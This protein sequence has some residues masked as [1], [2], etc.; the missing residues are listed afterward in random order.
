[1][2]RP[3][4]KF[5]AASKLRVV[6]S[7]VLVAIL[8]LVARR[9]CQLKF[10]VTDP[11]LWWH[12][13][14]GDWILANHALPHT[15]IFSRIAEQRPWTAY[16]WGYEVLLSFAYRCFGIF[17]VGVFGVL[18]TL[19]V[20]CA[21]FLMLHRLSG[22][23][24]VAAG[25]SLVTYFA[26]L[27][28]MMPRPHF[29]S[30]ALFCSLITLIFEARRHSSLTPLFALPLLFLLWA[31]LH[32][33]FIY[34]LAVFGL[35]VLVNAAQILLSRFNHTSPSLQPPGLRSGP[36]LLI[37]VLA[38]LATFV[39]PNT[40][41]LY[42][43]ILDYSHAKFGYAYIREL[44]ALDFRFADHF[45]Q[46]LLTGAAFFVLGWQ[47]KTNA[48]KLLLLLACALVAFRTTRDGWFICIPAA[49]CLADFFR[50]LN[51]PEQAPQANWRLVDYL[52]S[53]AVTLLLLILLFPLSGFTPL[54]LDSAVA[55]VFPIKAANFL[56]R[57]PPAGP[58][59]NSF[60]WGGFIIWYLPDYPVAI[61]GRN[62]LYGDDLD[63]RFMRV[64]NGFAPYA[65]DAIFR[66][67]RLIL[68]NNQ[69]YLTTLLARDPRYRL[70]YRD[71]LAS[72]F[73]P[74]A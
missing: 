38:I 73:V 19:M 2:Q 28:T 54:A 42:T 55:R 69:D 7:S 4:E 67:S 43:A 27:F 8:L 13:K 68:L 50:Q 29:F 24:W 58:I 60:G 33:Q 48:F 5:V 16:S 53:A 17:G 59:Y 71:E 66:Q 15:G 45:L 34:G 23:F 25:L 41:H 51:Q 11:D 64:L 9:S 62:D 44:Q 39:G 6:Q 32:I 22:S 35:F 47:K 12:L 49:A 52:A 3:F 57:Y 40:Y 36:L 70:I 61:D 1:M 56:R 31:N 37:F 30:I 10:C 26:M 65:G 21:I 18:L 46:L 14:V 63:F 74:L 72:I 20:A